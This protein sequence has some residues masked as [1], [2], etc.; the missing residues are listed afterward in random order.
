MSIPHPTTQSANAPIPPPTHQG[1]SNGDSP[2]TNHVHPSPPTVSITPSHIPSLGT[3]TPRP[4]EPTSFTRPSGT[5][6]AMTGQQHPHPRLL[7]GTP[8]AGSFATRIAELD[9]PTASYMR[10]L[11]ESVEAARIGGEALRSDGRG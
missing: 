5:A 4:P 10:E 8:T 6:P 1:L 7:A 2:L 3:A 11:I 9:D